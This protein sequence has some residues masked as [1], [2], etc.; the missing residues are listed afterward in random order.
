[1]SSGAPQFGRVFANARSLY[2]IT[3]GE[4]GH[5]PR[6]LE[7]GGIETGTNLQLLECGSLQVMGTSDS[8]S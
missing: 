6:L 2:R 7:S 8:F 3:R 4:K 1:M 5:H